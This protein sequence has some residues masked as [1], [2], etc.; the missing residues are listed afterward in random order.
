[1]LR[2]PEVIASVALRDGQQDRSP[3]RQDAGTR[4][5][6]PEPGGDLLRRPVHEEGERFPD[7]SGEQDAAH[8]GRTD[9][10]Q[11]RRR[12]P[13]R[14]QIEGQAIG[15]RREDGTCRG[16]HRV[17]LA[18][19]RRS[20]RDVRLAQTR[21]TER[22]ALD[23]RV[24]RRSDHQNLAAAASDVD[25]NGLSAD[26][27]PGLDPEEREQCLFVGSENLNLNA[28]PA[29]DRGHHSRAVGGPSQRIRGDDRQ[30]RRSV[31]AGQRVIALE[32]VGQLQGRL[33]AQFAPRVHRG[34]ESQ[35]DRFVD[36]RDEAM[37]VDLGHEEVHGVR[38]DIDGGTDRRGP[39]VRGR[40]RCGHERS[41]ARRAVAR[42]RP[43]LLLR[44]PAPASADAPTSGPGRVAADPPLTPC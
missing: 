9:S 40:S 42:G 8:Q 24:A 21:G 33:R 35:R 25:E 15:R 23:H 30:G 36:D 27:L 28:D 16:E 18:C 39:G 31:A 12:S 38:P 7:S 14:D 19:R 37:A 41:V 17:H 10:E 11:V 22:Q 4:Q 29:A 34:A 20:T 3:T 6:H 13:D 1:M 32:N 2:D 44:P 26:G 43:H 5:L